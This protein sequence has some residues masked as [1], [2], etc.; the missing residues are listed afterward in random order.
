MWPTLLIVVPAVSLAIVGGRGPKAVLKEADEV[1]GVAEPCGV[2]NGLDREVGA[3]QQ[4]L[5]ILQSFAHHPAVYA[6]AEV[7]SEFEFE[8]GGA[9]ATL[10]CE[11][12]DTL[13]GVYTLCCHL[14]QVLIKWRIGVVLF[15]H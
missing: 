12:F 1:R 14:V 9:E 6:L 5:G 13:F 7:A 10:L 11:L 3:T 4:S 8:C 15:C 2:G